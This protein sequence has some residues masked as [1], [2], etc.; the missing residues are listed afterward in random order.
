MKINESIAPIFKN[1]KQNTFSW[2]FCKFWLIRFKWTTLA[3][4]LCS[5]SLLAFT[6][7]VCRKTCSLCSNIHSLRYIGSL[8]PPEL[9]WMSVNESYICR[10]KPEVSFSFFTYRIGKKQTPAS[11]VAVNKKPVA[12]TAMT[13]DKRTAIFKHITTAAR[14]I[15]L[16]DCINCIINMYCENMCINYCR[17]C[18]E[19]CE[20][21]NTCRNYNYWKGQPRSMT[22]ERLRV[23]RKMLKKVQLRYDWL[24]RTLVE[25]LYTWCQPCEIL[26]YFKSGSFKCSET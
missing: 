17:N 3:F 11:M 20:D 7:T 23:L 13:T 22:S 2:E 16:F 26:E 18:R 8:K 4:S 10:W 19:L 14:P 12:V 21:C 5:Q 9:V 24:C 15:C 6:L 1:C 25:Y